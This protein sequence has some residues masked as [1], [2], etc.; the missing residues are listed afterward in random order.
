MDELIYDEL[1]PIYQRVAVELAARIKQMFASDETLEAAFHKRVQRIAFDRTK[2]WNTILRRELEE[3]WEEYGLP[4]KAPPTIYDER[5][6]LKVLADL[7]D[8]NLFSQVLLNLQSW[9]PIRYQSFDEV[10]KALVLNKKWEGR[11]PSIFD[12]KP[13]MFKVA[14]NAQEAEYNLD[15][16]TLKAMRIIT[17][18]TLMKSFRVSPIGST[19][20][21]ADSQN[22]SMI[23]VGGDEFLQIPKDFHA[24]YY[25]WEQAPDIL[26]QEG[27]SF[28]YPGIDYPFHSKSGGAILNEV[29]F[30]R[31]LTAFLFRSFGPEAALLPR[32]MSVLMVCKADPSEVEEHAA[33]CTQWII[34]GVVHLHTARRAP[35]PDEAAA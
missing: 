25:T 21:L 20:A 13:R 4:V 22:L 24:Y 33:T 3:V 29:L 30:A 31:R 23:G 8:F 26:V 7:L 6:I 18:Q 2:H 28:Q 11:V 19:P 27:S 17:M 34:P 5:Q 35:L 12:A 9:G 32:M 1:E 15:L 14:A 16:S 10:A